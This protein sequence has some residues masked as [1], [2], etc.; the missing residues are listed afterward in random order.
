MLSPSDLLPSLEP[1]PRSDVPLGRGG[2]VLLIE[3]EESL[4]ELLKHLLGRLEV[5]VLH[6]ANGA[7]ALELLKRHGNAITLAFVDC[8]LPDM[9]GSDVCHELREVLPG[10][11]LLLTSGRDQRALEALFAAKGPCSFLPKPYMPGDVTR[12]VNALLATAA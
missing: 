8:H 5:K 7:Q 1:A 6:A 2:A 12:H 4:A 11:P 9:A 3:D 10:L